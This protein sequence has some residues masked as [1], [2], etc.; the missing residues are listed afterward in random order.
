MTNSLFLDNQDANS[1]TV[2]VEE[3]KTEVHYLFI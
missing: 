1:G 2:K 3:E